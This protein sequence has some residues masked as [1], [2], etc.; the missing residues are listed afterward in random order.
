MQKCGSLAIIAF[1]ICIV[2]TLGIFDFN[3][4]KR[5]KSSHET[6]THYQDKITHPA[7]YYFSKENPKQL[8]K[9]L[10]NIKLL[11]L[12]E[13]EYEYIDVQNK[14]AK[15]T[16]TAELDKDEVSRKINKKY[17]KIFRIIRHDLSEEFTKRRFKFLT[18]SLNLFLKTIIVN[19]N[20]QEEGKA[21]LAVQRQMIQE[22]GSNILQILFHHEDFTEDIA[23][24]YVKTRRTLQAI[25]IIMNT[26][27][28][29]SNQLKVVVDEF[30][31]HDQRPCNPISRANSVRSR[32]NHDF[33][34]SDLNH[35]RLEAAIESSKNTK[36]PFTSSSKTR[37][38]RDTGKISS[39]IDSNPGTTVNTSRAWRTIDFFATD[40]SKLTC[41]D[42]YPDYFYSKRPITSIYQIPTAPEAVV[43][44]LAENPD[45][46]GYT[47][48]ALFKKW[49]KELNM[50]DDE[51][52]Y[53]VK[54]YEG[55]K[56]KAELQKDYDEMV[57][58]IIADMEPEIN[59]INPQWS[60]TEATKKT[61]KK[62]V[63]TGTPP[64]TREPNATRRFFNGS[65]PFNFT[66][67]T[68]K[69]NSTPLMR[70]KF[71][72][73][74]KVKNKTQPTPVRVKRDLTSR[75]EHNMIRTTTVTTTQ[76]PT[77]YIYPKRFDRLLPE[78][79]IG[80]RLILS[81]EVTR[82]HN[83]ISRRRTTA[84]N[85]LNFHRM[86]TTGKYEE[87]TTVDTAE[88]QRQWEKRF[89]M[90]RRYDSVTHFD[91]NNFPLNETGKDKWEYGTEHYGTALDTTTMCDSD[92]L[93]THTV[94]PDFWPESNFEFNEEKFHHLM[95]ESFYDVVGFTKA[96]VWFNSTKKT[97]HPRK[98]LRFTSPITAA[99]LGNA[100]INFV[101]LLI[102]QKL[103]E[104]AQAS[105]KMTS[106]P[107]TPSTVTF[108]YYVLNQSYITKFN[109]L[110]HHFE[111]AK[112]GRDLVNGT[113][114][115]LEK[116]IENVGNFLHDLGDHLGEIELAMKRDVKI[117]VDP[118]DKN[119]IRTTGFIRYP[120]G[121][122]YQDD[123][124][125]QSF[126][127]KFHLSTTN[128]PNS[129]EFYA[130]TYNPFLQ[131]FVNFARNMRDYEREMTEDKAKEK[132]MEI[133]NQGRASHEKFN[134]SEVLQIMRE[135]KERK[136]QELGETTKEPMK[137]V[138][139]QEKRE[140]R[141]A[142]KKAEKARKRLKAN[143]T[144]IEG[145]EDEVKDL[146]QLK[147]EKI[148]LRRKIFD[149]NAN[150]Q[151]VTAKKKKKRID[152]AAFVEDSD[153]MEDE[154][155]DMR[156]QVK[157]QNIRL[158][159]QTTTE[160]EPIPSE[161]LEEMRK[162][163]V[164]PIE[165]FEGNVTYRKLNRYICHDCE[166]ENASDVFRTKNFTQYVDHYREHHF[167][168][169]NR[170]KY[171]EMVA[172]KL[173]YQ[174]PYQC[175]HCDFYE[176]Y[177]NDVCYDHYEKDHPDKNHYDV[178]GH[179]FSMRRYYLDLK[180]KWPQN[181]SVELKNYVADLFATPRS[182]GGTTECTACQFHH[183]T[184]RDEEFYSRFYVLPT[185]E[186][187]EER[188]Y[189]ELL[190]N[191]S[192]VIETKEIRIPKWL[193]R[194]CDKYR[195]MPMPSGELLKNLSRGIFN[196]A[197]GENDTSEFR[198]DYYPSCDYRSK[199]LETGEDMW[200]SSCEDRM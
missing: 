173:G 122:R 194:D 34:R 14:Q 125:T 59:K 196:S 140:E 8:L 61:Q 144:Q 50:T 154:E 90:R 170:S 9:V 153:Y 96:P 52:Q 13:L 113:N 76:L 48:P 12:Y 69:K 63:R 84:W 182:A 143:K 4:F 38:V 172:W 53:A 160:L 118:Y 126:R 78:R 46:H 37:R 36:F 55:N 18:R 77:T 88:I 149:N 20:G 91:W 187:D 169:Y 163:W 82:S 159:M 184:P 117:S 120:T 43:L 164:R 198:S 35:T 27:Q 6:P 74:T 64:V 179:V 193:Q 16:G 110:F 161:E 58:K 21:L 142:S 166:M 28:Q 60:L 98:M 24:L 47:R 70:S 189:D 176:P 168:M 103:K 93:K 41:E 191:R 19:K 49:M 66:R 42:L 25:G 62:K 148:E 136:R 127:E 17:R 56:T 95:Y 1:I 175:E 134:S 177:D 129:D 106:P 200:G 156:M 128:T 123:N 10:T 180:K 67:W 99:P 147:R 119:E 133:I 112:D 92:Y 40:D 115:E 30:D 107:L 81:D 11:L 104:Y 150:M 199:T 94:P 183:P 114:F 101:K 71:I 185:T 51:F 65:R 138:E 3:H 29:D 108:P 83:E 152:D 111:Y 87:D 68:K 2:I 109:D 79:F 165:E 135:E 5:R 151:K 31:N 157:K 132:L 137:I 121:Q 174:N 57:E 85:F 7:K 100:T 45:R 73:T 186:S 155:G 158:Q 72:K 33:S 197:S 39:T 178:Y 171:M 124:Q 102:K 80:D 22:I 15:I 192:D 130:R 105:A 146:Q 188:N 181:S 75:R 145:E 44:N 139:V 131:D 141:K 116:N 162:D 167:E 89:A 190:G 86:R 195:N 97:K 23:I 54:A 26:F 32:S